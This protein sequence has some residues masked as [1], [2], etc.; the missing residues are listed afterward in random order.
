L[1]KINV[2]KFR[3]IMNNPANHPV[4]VHCLAGKHRTGAMCAVFR[5]EQDHWSNQQAI[6]EVELYGFD[7][8]SETFDVLRY[9]EQYR[10][11]WCQ[12]TA[13]P[14]LDVRHTSTG[15]LQEPPQHVRRRK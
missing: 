4:L 8:L 9:L 2:I 1:P 10:P 5:M 15:E 6:K 7:N 11:L 14:P 13:E 12:P 3:E